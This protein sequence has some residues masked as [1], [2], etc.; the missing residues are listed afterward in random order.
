VRLTVVL[1]RSIIFDEC[2]SYRRPVRS[3]AGVCFAGDPQV[4]LTAWRGP[5]MVKFIWPGFHDTIHYICVKSGTNLCKRR[6]VLGF[7]DTFVDLLLHSY[8]GNSDISLWACTPFIVSCY[9]HKDIKK[10]YCCW[11]R[12]WIKQPTWGGVFINSW[13]RAC[14]FCHGVG[15]TLY[16]IGYYVGLR[17][18]PFY[19]ILYSRCHLKEPYQERIPALVQRNPWP[20]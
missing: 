1:K 12:V 2:R 10:M 16:L 11:D 14:A 6:G 7:A 17:R 13:S 5:L 18:K 3:W 20:V 4:N 8:P 19:I 15:P 9:D